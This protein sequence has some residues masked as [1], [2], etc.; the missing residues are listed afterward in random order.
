MEKIGIL[1]VSYGARAVAMV[2]S[3]KRSTNYDVELYIADK[4]RNPFNV[5]KAVKHVVI[6]D[7]DAE[8]ICKF[9]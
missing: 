1:V 4:Q 8:K 5:K 7:L 3:F 9:A 6:P 2:D